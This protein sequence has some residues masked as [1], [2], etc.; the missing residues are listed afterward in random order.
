MGCNCGRRA[1]NLTRTYQAA[2][3]GDI[4]TMRTEMA[5][6]VQSSKE[7]IAELNR[8]ASEAVARFKRE[9]GFQR[10]DGSQD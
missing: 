7:D 8:I 6:F 2:T 4:A 3:R 9:R 5:D 1:I 10:A